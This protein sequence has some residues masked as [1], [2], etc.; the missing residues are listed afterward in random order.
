MNGYR[1]GFLELVR[2]APRVETRLGIVAA[3][4]TVGSHNDQR[5][6]AVSVVATGFTRMARNAPNNK[7]TALQTCAVVKRSPK[8]QADRATAPSGHI[9]WS[10]WDRATPISWMAT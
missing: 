4:V 5:F 9:S 2:K 7:M 3:I 8:I 1:A 6:S 10:V